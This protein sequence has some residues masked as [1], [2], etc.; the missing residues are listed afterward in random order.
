MNRQ[1]HAEQ[2]PRL[3][4]YR[5][6]KPSKQGVVTILGRDYYLGR[7]GTPG[8]L[9]RY[10][11]LIGEWQAGGCK[12][13]PGQTPDDFTVA[14]LIAAHLP[15]ARDRY[16]SGEVSNFRLACRPLLELYGSL[17][18]V[19][20]GPRALKAVRL[21]LAERGYV[22]TTVNG[23]VGRIRAVFRWGCSEELVPWE[24]YHAL[25]TVAGLRRGELGVAD[26]SKVRPVALSR[27]QALEPFLQP[28]V[29]AM[30]RLQLLTGM[31]PGEVVLMRGRDI[32]RGG[33][34]WTYAPA[35]HKNDWREDP[36]ER[37][38][39]LG[40]QAQAVLLPFLRADLDAWLF[41]P[42]ESMA[43][44][45]ASCRAER[46]ARGGVGS[47]KP[48]RPGYGTLRRDERRPRVV[49]GGR[50]TVDSYRRAIA[51]ACDRAWPPPKELRRRAGETIDAWVARLEAAGL[52]GELRAW[53]RRHRWHPH[54]LRHTFATAV[55]KRFG[56]E[57]A[58]VA[59][60][61]ASLDVT[62]IYAERDRELAQRI[63]REV[64]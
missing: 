54:Q 24:V 36:A 34:V 7:Y 29:W 47:H 37:L 64:G 52:A 33:A 51:R 26:G 22:R 35:E 41:S 18:V 60:G 39:D 1:A 3:P 40:P 9:Q 57:A 42:A 48:R 59:L 17:P 25:T 62:E 46:I 2:T 8:S 16:G 43:A 61:H 4:K 23:Y 15:Y 63:A 10:E 21:R 55:R 19:G 56:A 27:A 5:R 30:V 31:R 44:Y 11:R 28:A 12:Q 49:P 32:D 14:E 45:R 50:Y 53:Q 38:I 20:F 6:H 58:R 13:A